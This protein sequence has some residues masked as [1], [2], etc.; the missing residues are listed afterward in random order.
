MTETTRKIGRPSTFTQEIADRICEVISS[1]TRGLKAICDSYA[2]LPW[3]ST[4]VKWCDKFPA[5]DAQ[6]TRARERQAF[7]RIDECIDIAD[8]PQIGDEI[9]FEDGKEKIKRGDMLGHRKLRVDTRIALAAK[10]APKLFGNKLEVGGNVTVTLETI[11]LSYLGNKEPLNVT[12]KP[13]AL[14]KEVDV[15]DDLL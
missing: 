10:I 14:S 9:T 2:D 6:L 4:L 5:F 3:K 12:P 13:I 7:M 1:D 11:V 15:Y 8:T